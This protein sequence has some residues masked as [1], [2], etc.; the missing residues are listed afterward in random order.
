M[1]F[2]KA[3]WRKL[4]IAN[5]VIDKKIVEPYEFENAAQLMEDFWN[6]VERIILDLYG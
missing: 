1:S 4:A 2:L 6:D 3:E 5:Y